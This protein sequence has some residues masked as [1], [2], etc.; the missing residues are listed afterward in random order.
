MSVAMTKK[1]SKETANRNLPKM[2]SLNE[3]L[4]VANSTIAKTKQ[5]FIA[6]Q[7]IMST[8]CLLVTIAGTH[9]RLQG[10]SET[11]WVMPDDAPEG[12]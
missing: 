1:M 3:K 2:R 5:R 8:V 10:P 7:S 6:E 12:V 9:Y 4:S 11:P